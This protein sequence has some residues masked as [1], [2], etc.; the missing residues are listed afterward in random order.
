MYIFTYLVFSFPYF[1]LFSF[2]VLVSVIFL[3]VYYSLMLLFSAILSLLISTSEGIFIYVYC[4]FVLS[5]SLESFLELLSICQNYLSDLASYLPFQS[6]SLTLLFKILCHR[7]P[8]L[9]ISM[10]VLMIPLSLHTVICV[11]FSYVL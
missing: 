8:L 1:S 5:T 11:S 3:D 6:Q 10:S 9:S 4:T 7:G 2:S